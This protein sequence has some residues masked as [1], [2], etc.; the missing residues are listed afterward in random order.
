MEQNAPT[1]FLY[2]I[3]ATMDGIELNKW[4]G[5]RRLTDV[6]HALHCPLT[7][8][9]GRCSAPKPF[10]SIV[11]EHTS[12][13]HLYGYSSMNS[14]NLRLLAGKRL[15]DDKLRCKALGISTLQSK[16][17]PHDWRTSTSLRYEVRV[18]P[19]RRL[20]ETGRRETDV[21]LHESQL[22]KSHTLLNRE[23]VYT[24]WL[25]EQIAKIG[26]AVLEQSRMTKFQRNR[27]VRSCNSQGSEGPDAVLEGILRVT[28][29][30]KFTHL[31]MRG[32]GRHRTYGYGMLLLKPM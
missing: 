23:E 26:G 19:I 17:M 15:A 10:R 7:E 6:D 29:S 14:T 4:M 13:I 5:L 22:A 31:L 21:F 24:Q 16:P 1:K 25:H 11:N 18:R 20:A 12:D 3:H 9:F 2:M 32:V 28:D 8:A 27:A 30:E